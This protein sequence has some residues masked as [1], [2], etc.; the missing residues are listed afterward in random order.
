MV[1][2][3]IQKY[4]EGKSISQL[5]IEYP[6]YNRRQINKILT[7]NHIV[8]RG[9]RKRKE[10]TNNQIEEIKE[11]INNGAFL[12]EIANYFNFDKETMRNKLNEL[13]LTIKN[14]NRINRKIKSDFFSKIDS[15]IKAYW[16]GFLF[17]DGS[18][19]HYKTTGRIRLQLQEKDL[20]IL[21][22]FKE[23]LG[24]D[25]KIIYDIR[26]NSTCCSVEFVDEQ[27]FNDLG[28]YGIIPNKTYMTNRVPYDKIP[29]KYLK[30]F[31]LGLFD[32]DGNLNCSKDFTDVSLGYTAYHQTEVED[33]QY[34]INKLANIPT[35]NKIFFTSAWHTQWRG[36]RQ[37][38]QILDILYEN[39]PR[40]LK[41]KYDIY[42]AL[43]NSF[44]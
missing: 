25:S 1:N 18:V 7:E 32:G 4:K 16:L 33:F 35:K 44:N 19:D 34:L 21:E 38:L 26:D 2:E 20:E 3:I 40:F 8:I 14:K 27:I 42:L 17:T 41:R 39:N 30:N 11:M 43:K 15:P 5:L 36:R 13:G 31:V 6:S 24:I 9:G 37:V 12:V 10:L 29:E 28:K 23:D 22:K